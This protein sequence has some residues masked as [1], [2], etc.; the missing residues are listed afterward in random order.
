VANSGRAALSFGCIGNRT[1]TG[2]PDNE[3]YLAIPGDKWEAV[4]DAVEEITS[5]NASM[6]SYYRGTLVAEDSTST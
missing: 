5:A 6:E 2:L 1:Y 3:L 4:A